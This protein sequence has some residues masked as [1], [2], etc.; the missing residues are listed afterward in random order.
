[1]NIKIRLDN[2]ECFMIKHS[3]SKG[4]IDFASLSAEG[5]EECIVAVDISGQ[6]YARQG[7]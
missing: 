4:T 2:M 3:F 5:S 1:M 7:A 6:L